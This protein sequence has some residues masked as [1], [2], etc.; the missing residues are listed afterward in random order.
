MKK[1]IILFFILTNICYA[2]FSEGENNIWGI[3]N[4]DEKGSEISAKVSSMGKYKATLYY[5]LFDPDHYY[6][7]GPKI[8]CEDALISIKEI[9]PDTN[10]KNIIYLILEDKKYQ[11]VYGERVGK[12]ELLQGKAA[13]HFIDRDHMWL[14]LVKNDSKYPT[15]PDFPTGFFRGPSEI[16]W[17][18]EKVEGGK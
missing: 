18:A 3:W 7:R 5:L 6:Y 8:D 15:H 4:G 14:E 12:P 9:I 1:T 10:N 16:F 11:Y 2:C 13:M 17:R